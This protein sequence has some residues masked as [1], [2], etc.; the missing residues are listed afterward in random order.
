M[1]KTTSDPWDRPR[2][3]A[4]YGSVTAKPIYTAVGEGLSRWEEIE[5]E[6][7]RLFAS[8]SRIELELAYLLYAN[9]AS[10]AMKQKMLDLAFQHT[11]RDKP[12]HLA[13]AKDVLRMVGRFGERRNDLAH[14]IVKRTKAGFF[15]Q[16]PQHG[17]RGFDYTLGRTKYAYN[18][19]DIRRLTMCF[20]W[21]LME[22]HDVFPLLL[23]TVVTGSSC[24]TPLS[25]YILRSKVRLHNMKKPAALPPPPEPSPA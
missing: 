22:L 21:L 19:F 24:Q 3:R 12:E 2:E 9:L 25:P 20:G 4:T 7:I 16:G 14:G 11:F 18:A 6:L 8:V 13:Y 15:L 23:G 5:G 1:T 10:S 17:A